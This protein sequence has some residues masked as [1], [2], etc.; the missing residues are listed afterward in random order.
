MP[1]MPK[2]FS[3]YY[4]SLLRESVDVYGSGIMARSLNRLAIGFLLGTIVLS[5]DIQG[6]RAAD[7]PALYVSSDEPQPDD[8]QLQAG[9]IKVIL[10]S[11][12]DTEMDRKINLEYQIFYNEHLKISDRQETYYFGEVSLRPLRDGPWLDVVVK[13]FTGGSRC[14]IQHHIFAW[15]GD[16]FAQIE[17]GPLDGGGEFKDLD[18]D[19]R[20]EL[21]SIDPAF[22]YTFAPY[23]GSF[24]PAAIYRLEQDQL[25]NVTQDYPTYLKERAMEMYT[26]ILEAKQ[27]NIPVNG[28]LAGYVGQMA[29]IGEFE[30]A[31]QVMLD[32]YNPEIDWG[33]TRYNEAGEVIQEFPDFPTALKFFLE[34]QGYI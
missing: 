24:P 18:G 20:E 14:C 8:R 23:A 1:L 2:G 22:L 10:R 16:R 26:T 28:A 7:V 19:G 31:W 6:T 21:V 27:D 30:Q 25:V 34:E 33:L 11:Q 12:P 9:G 32:N 17:T 29:L 15:Q 13:T 3:P 4:H 5:A